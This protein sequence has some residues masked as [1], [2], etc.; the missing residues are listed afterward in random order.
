MYTAPLVTD[1]RNFDSLGGKLTRYL[2]CGPSSTK[3]QRSLCQIVTT[4]LKQKQ[5][6]FIYYVY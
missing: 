2:D 4:Y 3:C 1:N 6:E 5:R